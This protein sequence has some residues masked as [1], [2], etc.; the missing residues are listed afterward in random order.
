MVFFFVEVGPE[1][2]KGVRCKYGQAFKVRTDK[3]AKYKKET[4]RNKEAPWVQQHGDVIIRTSHSR[5]LIPR[6]PGNRSSKIWIFCLKLAPTPVI[7]LLI[8]FL[9]GYGSI[10]KV[11][12][13][14]LLRIDLVFVKEH[15]ATGTLRNAVSW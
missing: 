13:D 8:A 10:D 6:N 12:R 4:R 1:H 2:I 7:I 5:G 9:T 15:P 3:K 11:A 14:G